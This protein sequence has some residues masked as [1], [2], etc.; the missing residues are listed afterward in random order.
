MAAY[1]QAKKGMVSKSHGSQKVLD[2]VWDSW[3]RFKV[4]LF[5][6]MGSRRRW[7]D[8]CIENRLFMGGSLQG[9]SFS[10]ST[11]LDN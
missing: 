2:S 6:T 8:G 4:L 11:Y 7:T 5:L 10:Y 1:E 9:S 3:T